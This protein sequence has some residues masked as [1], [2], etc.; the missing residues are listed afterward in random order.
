MKKFVSLTLILALASA[1]TVCFAKSELIE[2]STV[3]VVEQEHYFTHEE[4]SKI[5]NDAAQ[6]ELEAIKNGKPLYNNNTVIKDNTVSEKT[7]V[8]KP[9]TLLSFFKSMAK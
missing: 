7:E 4:M 2:I 6:A 5:V 1:S 3:E 9:G 8:K